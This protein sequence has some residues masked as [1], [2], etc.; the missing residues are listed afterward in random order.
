MTKQEAQ[1]SIDIFA[2]TVYRDLKQNGYC[3]AD[4]V[5]FAS[6]ILEQITSDAKASGVTAE[7]RE[8]TV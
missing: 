4:I 6:C 8:T 7:T 1:R 5:S 2:K 3:R